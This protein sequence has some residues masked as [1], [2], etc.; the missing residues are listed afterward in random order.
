MALLR[1]LHIPRVNLIGASDGAIIGLDIAMREAGLVNS[2]FAQGANVTVSGTY[3][4]APIRA[5]VRTPIDSGS[6]ITRACHR[7]RTSMRN[8]TQ[9]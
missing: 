9:Q 6:S 7:R 8:S 2:L 5:P 3:D 1:Y 4:T